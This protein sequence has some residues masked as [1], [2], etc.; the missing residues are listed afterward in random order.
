MIHRD[1]KTDNIL[2]TNEASPV[3]LL[4]DFGLSKA[5]VNGLTPGFCSAEQLKKNALV[6][7][8][9]DIHGLGVV[10]IISLFKGESQKLQSDIGLALLFTPISSIPTQNST[11]TN[12]LRQNKIVQLVTKMV[13]YDPEKR[14]DFDFIQNEL[15]AIDAVSTS[16][17][18]PFKS[19]I[20]N[21]GETMADLSIIDTSMILPTNVGSKLVSVAI[22]DQL[23]SGLCW[24]FSTAK[25]VAA[26]L[27]KFIKMLKSKK[28]LKPE[29]ADEALRM[30]DVVNDGN[31]LVNEIVCLLAPRNPKLKEITIDQTIA[32]TAEVEKQIQKLCS[33][34]IIRPEGWKILPSL[35]TITEKA[36]TGSKI[37]IDEI[38][39]V[40]QTHHHPLSKNH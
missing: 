32:Q 36:I 1:V 40:Y 38:E 12:Q 8:K 30:A 28:I 18:L 33:E 25:L 13:Q 35:R 5:D 10:T 9:T 4:A 27:R 6:P 17:Q 23:E 3:A 2:I 24:A 11:I 26:E 14:P 29:A 31:R 19:D 7:R 37:S 21:L 22:R 20:Q 34:S 15:A 16:I 39:L